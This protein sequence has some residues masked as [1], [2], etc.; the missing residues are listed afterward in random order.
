MEIARS[1][2]WFCLA[3]VCEL[4]G[5]YAIWLWLREGR[6]AWLGALGAGILA[7]YG[8]VHTLQPANYGRVQAA[9]SGFFIAMALLWGWRVD[10]VIPDKFDLIG[11][12]I[13]LVGVCVIMY[14]PRS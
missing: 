3:G 8:Y 9:Y 4:G 5:A 1:V 6:S 7:L 12:G 13:A 10:K 2:G 11:T 14:W